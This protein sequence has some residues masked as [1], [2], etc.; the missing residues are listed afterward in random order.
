MHGFHIGRLALHKFS[1]T[2]VD[3]DDSGFLWR[4][5]GRKG[6]QWLHAAVDVTLGADESLAFVG[7]RGDEYSGDIGLDSLQLKTGNCS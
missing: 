6:N 7:H 5:V 4:R 3:V 2:D 1:P